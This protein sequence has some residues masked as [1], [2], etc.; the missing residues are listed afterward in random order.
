MSSAGETLKAYLVADTAGVNSVVSGRVH[1]N[2][3]PIVSSVPHIWFRRSSEQQVTAF[4]GGTGLHNARFDVECIATTADS[5]IDLADLVKSRLH[6]VKTTTGG[7][8][9]LT[10]LVEDHD[11]DYAPKAIG[12]DEGLHVSALDLTMW[13]TT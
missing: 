8:N 7:V 2:T 12:S 9:I 5:A 6:A 1:Q 4:S 3:I 13:Y 10:M 11:D